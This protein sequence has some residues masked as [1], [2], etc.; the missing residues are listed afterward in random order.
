MADMRRDQPL[1][2]SVV[3]APQKNHEQEAGGGDGVIFWLRH[4]ASKP[5]RD[6]IANEI[7]LAVS[8]DVNLQA[9]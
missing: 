7:C 1:G 2:A 5:M 9:A 8:R 3:A 6:R 4:P